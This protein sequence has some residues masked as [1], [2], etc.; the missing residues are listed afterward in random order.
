MTTINI[1]YSGVPTTNPKM[2]T[3][4]ASRDGSVVVNGGDW[5]ALTV[6][7]D[8]PPTNYCTLVAWVVF[9]WMLVAAFN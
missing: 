3:I 6:T 5:V 8:E 7:E 4:Y 2:R 1:S 9:V